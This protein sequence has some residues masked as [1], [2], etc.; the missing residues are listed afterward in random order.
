[1]SKDELNLSSGRWIRREA[2]VDDMLNEYADED[3]VDKERMD[4]I[5]GEMIED[6]GILQTMDWNGEQY[7]QLQSALAAFSYV[8]KRDPSQLP[9]LVRDTFIN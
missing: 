7:I 6:D 5:I 1:M 9:T 3:D 4:R 2:F 8:G